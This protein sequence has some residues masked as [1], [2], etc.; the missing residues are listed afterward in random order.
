MDF[1]QLSMKTHLFS[2]LFLF[3]PIIIFSQNSVDKTIYFDSIW[4]ETTVENYVYYRVIK[5]YYSDNETFKIY[6]YYKNGA[7]QMTG[8]SKTRDELSMEGQFVYYYENG[9][10]KQNSNYKKSRLD[11]KE[12]QWYENGAK[13]LEG[14]YVADNK[15]YTYELKINQFWD[16]KNVPK[17]IDGFGAYEEVIESFHAKGNI[18]NGFKDGVW[19]G[20][21]KKLKYTFTETYSNS[22]LISGTSIDSAKVVHNYTVAKLN[23]T[24]KKGYKD[25]YRFVGKNYNINKMAK[26][27]DGKIYVFFVVDKQGEIIEPRI[28]KSISY[29][30]DVEAMRVLKSYGNWNPGE[31]RGIKVKCSFT[32]PITI[33]PSR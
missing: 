7:I 19:E 21:D 12:F 10:K 27:T 24:P 4:K 25:F 16:D 2:I 17:V 13:R 26:G 29:N 30:A 32:L 31:I 5:D 9:N 8:T 15:T 33:Q 11:G 6:D 3:V 1:N 28:I 18:L 23:P 20:S 14:E 22:K